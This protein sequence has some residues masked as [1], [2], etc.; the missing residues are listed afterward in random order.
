MHL[1]RTCHAYATATGPQVSWELYQ[2]G[3]C[4]PTPLLAEVWRA[5]PGAAVEAAVPPSTS[6]TRVPHWQAKTAPAPSPKSEERGRR[7]ASPTR[8]RGG[9][10]RAS[11]ERVR[12]GGGTTGA[13]VEGSQP[14]L[15]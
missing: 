8:A 1:T 9:S 11:P 14:L 3:P 10:R 7:I 4:C 12:R 13:E 2:Q 5:P 6:L 15:F